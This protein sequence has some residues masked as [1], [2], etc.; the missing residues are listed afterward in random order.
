MGASGAGKTSLLNVLS[1]RILLKKGWATLT[2]SLKFNDSV[3][4]DQDIFG[5]FC[6]YVMQDDILFAYFTVKE[7]MT[8]AARLKLNDIPE[9]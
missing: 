4:V 8:F 3:D 1:D 6:S 7:A 5:K 2:G 9:E